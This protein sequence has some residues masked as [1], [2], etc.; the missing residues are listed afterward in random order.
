[1]DRLASQRALPPSLGLL[2]YVTTSSYYVEAGDKN[3]NACMTMAHGVIPSYI[4]NIDIL[5]N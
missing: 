4:L 2:M 3:S 5:Y 1:M